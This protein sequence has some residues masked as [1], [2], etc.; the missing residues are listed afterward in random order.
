M[1][2]SCLNVMTLELKRIRA[3]RTEGIEL[4]FRPRTHEL[5]TALILSKKLKSFN[6]LLFVSVV[7]IMNVSDEF[8]SFYVHV[9][10]CHFM[11]QNADKIMKVKNN[12]YYLQLTTCL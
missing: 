9:L 11:Q 12:E 6:S 3:G 5:L 2:V 1:G 7:Y 8:H 4:S 10:T